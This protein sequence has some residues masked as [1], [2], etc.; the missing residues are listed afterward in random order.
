MTRFLF[1]V[2]LVVGAGATAA[3]ADENPASDSGMTKILVTFAD[4]G[5]SNAA[6]GGPA[7]PGYRR[8]SSTYLTSVGVKRRDSS[9]TYSRSCS[10]EIMEA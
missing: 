7:G 9:S 10:V 6:R 5:M 1:M 8:R 2:F 3:V 4:P